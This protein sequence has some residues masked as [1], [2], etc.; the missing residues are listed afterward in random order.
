MRDVPLL[1][2]LAAVLAG[3]VLAWAFTRWNNRS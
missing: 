3:G 1:H 2:Y